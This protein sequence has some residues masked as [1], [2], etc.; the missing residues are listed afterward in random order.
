MRA[1]TVG[2]LVAVI[3]VAGAPEAASAEQLRAG[4]AAATPA[5]RPAHLT[6][7]GRLVAYDPATRSLVVQSAVGRTVYQAAEDTRVWLG[8]RRVPLDQL[9]RHVG[10]QATLAYGEVEGARVTHTIRL[11]E[12]QPAH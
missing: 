9:A 6:A 2:A 11:N 1:V 12:R 7:T 5:A 8:T 3:M 4:F 10:A